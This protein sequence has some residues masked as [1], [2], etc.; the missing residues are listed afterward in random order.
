MHFHLLYVVLQLSIKEAQIY[1]L[2]RIGGK[3][4]NIWPSKLL[5]LKLRNFTLDEREAFAFS[6]NDNFSSM[7]LHNPYGIGKLSISR[8]KTCNLSSDGCKKKKL[9]A[10]D[11]AI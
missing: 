10:F 7:Q 11:R 6:R 5:G 9:T 3:T 1:S 4:K 8:A 2:G